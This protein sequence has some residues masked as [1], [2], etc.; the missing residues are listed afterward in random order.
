MKVKRM[1][2]NISQSIFTHINF[3]LSLLGYMRE[4]DLYCP[5]LKKLA[6]VHNI[7]H[8]NIYLIINVFLYGLC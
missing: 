1:G 3:I 8:P 6:I 5:Y 7:F 4:Y 2:V